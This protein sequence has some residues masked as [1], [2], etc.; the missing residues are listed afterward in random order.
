MGDKAKVKTAR[1]GLIMKK[2]IVL[3]GWSLIADEAIS[4]GIRVRLKARP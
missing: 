1:S 2:V 4:H 3:N